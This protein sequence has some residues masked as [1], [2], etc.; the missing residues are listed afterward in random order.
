MDKEFYLIRHAQSMSNIGMDSG[1]D[2]DLSP[3]GHAQAK[4]CGILMQEYC[5]QD[6]LLLSSPFERCLKT[7]EAIAEPNG[8]KIRMMPVLHEFFARDWFP[9]MNK[10]KLE[11]LPEKAAKHSLVEGYY[12]NEQ[13]WPETNETSEEV[14]IRMAMF[15]NRLLSN[16]FKAEKIIC[17]GHWA[18]IASLANSMVPG[19]DLPI[20]D[21]ATVTAINYEDGQFTAEFI[22]K[23]L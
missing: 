19:I 5:D 21:N 18:S 6:T 10:I 20:V 2:S 8:L 22:N 13:W 17:I 15:R 23:T 12:A 3:E 16:E 1:D 4:Q 11:S 9:S 14:E 7:A